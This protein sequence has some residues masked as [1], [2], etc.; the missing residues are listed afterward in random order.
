MP[1]FG[2]AL[3]EAMPNSFSAFVSLSQKSTF[4]SPCAIDSAQSSSCPR[5]GCSVTTRDAPPARSSGFSPSSSHAHVLRYHAVGRTCIVSASGP[6]FVTR[7]VMRM[8][9]GSPFA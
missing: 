6:A 7:T 4:G 5:N 1:S 2:V 8:S 9:S 3:A